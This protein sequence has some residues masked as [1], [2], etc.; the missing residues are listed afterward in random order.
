MFS[1]FGIR[2]RALACITECDPASLSWGHQRPLDI[3]VGPWHLGLEGS[4]WRRIR[5]SRA[6]LRELTLFP[7]EVLELATNAFQSTILTSLQFPEAPCPWC[8]ECTQGADCL[9][10]CSTYIVPKSQRANVKRGVL[11][12][13]IQRKKRTD[14]RESKATEQFDTYTKLSRLHDLG[15]SRA[16]LDY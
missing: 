11:T 8:I 16:P 12:I 14:G 7:H 2:R 5:Y 10:D 6:L 9:P 4:T 15:L 13:A 1:F 3:I